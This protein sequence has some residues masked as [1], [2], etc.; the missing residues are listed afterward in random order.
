MVSTTPQHHTLPSL[1][2]IPGQ[3]SS[4]HVECPGQ[5]FV[6]VDRLTAAAGDGIVIG[7]KVKAGLAAAV[8]AVAAYTLLRVRALKEIRVTTLR[9]AP[10]MSLD[11]ISL[12]PVFYLVESCA[13][14]A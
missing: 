2:A 9:E 5:I 8:V 1:F 11:K 7:I 3:S 13:L 4:S 14:D 6:F 10:S 12:T